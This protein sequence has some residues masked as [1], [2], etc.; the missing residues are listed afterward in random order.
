MRLKPIVNIKTWYYVSLLLPILVPELFNGLTT[1]LFSK[2][3]QQEKW[4]FGLWGIINDALYFSLY[5]GGSQYFVFMLG[6]MLWGRNKSSAQFDRVAL[7][8]P[9]LF[10]PVCGLGAFLMHLGYGRQNVAENAAGSIVL[11]L[12]AL[13]YGYAYVG[14][15]NQL[16]TVFKNANLFKD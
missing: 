2:S 5:L 4:F 15:M 11:A 6:V 14:I 16:T 8:L 13:G 3:A 9:L 1:V 10:A 7:F 12:F